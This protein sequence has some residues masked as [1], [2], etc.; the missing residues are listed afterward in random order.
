MRAV[1]TAGGTSEPIDDVRVLTNASTGRFGVAIA[2]A[3][4]ARGAEV[5]LLLAR[6]APRDGVD[7]RV[8]I[9]P[10]GSVRE[11]SA[12]MDAAVARG[13]DL[14]FMAAAVSDYTPSPT[15]GKLRSDLDTLTLTLTRV[16]KLLP[17]L[18]PRLPDAVLVGFKLLSRVD[19][20]ELVRVATAQLRANGLSAVLANDWSRL[21]GG[22][23]PAQLVRADG[24][25]L[26]L[27]G[28]R[29]QVAGALVDAVWPRPPAP[30]R[31]GRW[32]GAW[33]VD[34]PLGALFPGVEG[35]WWSRDALCADA[36]LTGP[37]WPD[38]A[39][40]LHE[41]AAAAVLRAAPRGPGFAVAWPDGRAVVGV[42][43]AAETEARFGRYAA[44]AAFGAPRALFAGGALVGVWERRAAGA[45]VFVA[46]EHRGRGWG[47]AV[48]AV[49]DRRGMPVVAP[50]TTPFWGARGF[51]ADGTPPSARADLRDAASACLFDPFHR[52]VLVGRR[53]VGPAAGWWAFPGGKTEEGESPTT[54]ALR[55]L[56]EETGVS[57]P[58][59]VVERGV[60]VFTAGYR[61]HAR[62]FLVPRAEPPRPTA[63]LDAR[64]L[65]LDEALALRP[66]AAGAR[67][68]LLQ[69]AR[70][71]P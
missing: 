55:E 45:A 61:I 4:A 35:V 56:L 21:R 62:V 53:L 48:A 46:P 51:A 70:A 1:V 13:P 66:L 19:D 60:R 64:W 29:E 30:V 32:G 40:E 27:D 37:P 7:P 42:A 14:W 5:E 31:P 15:A 71:H 9:T 44:D 25:V 18:R 43:D 39:P 58:L 50:P 47:T 6:S 24:S 63:E 57:V 52:R 26:A 49:L 36:V 38:G 16:P 10:F 17:T 28:P 34:D 23:H 65:P 22:R 11:L 3:L 54:A 59:V 67:E 8:V 33:S 2:T 69:L 20:D 68:V 41:A 12:A